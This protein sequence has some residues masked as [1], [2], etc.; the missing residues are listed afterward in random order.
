MT[1]INLR[2]RTSGGSSEA[3]AIL[4]TDIYRM[5]IVEAKLEEDTFAQPNRDGTKPL[6]I[7]VTWEVSALTEEQQDAAREADEDWGKVRVWQRLNPY[8]GDVKDGGPSRF[9]AFIDGLRQQ[10]LLSGF[11]E[12]AFALES[13]IGIEQRVSI[14]YYLKTMGVNA[15]QPGNKVLSVAPL[16]KSKP[17]AAPVAEVAVD[18][19]E[20]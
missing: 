12:E 6:K 16:R 8:Y 3:R 13:L 20:Y 17:K 4:P 15:G 10:E 18:A 11:N 9:K 5:K 1:T 7:A 14:E 19:N 2:E